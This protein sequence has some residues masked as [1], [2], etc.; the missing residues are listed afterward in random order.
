MTSTRTTL[1]LVGG[2]AV[3]AV[4]QGVTALPGY[5]TAAPGWGATVV[6]S[7]LLLIA[8][9]SVAS[10]AAVRLAGGRPAA[11]RTVVWSAIVVVAG[12]AVAVLVPMLLVP[13]VVVASAVLSAA[14]AGDPCGWP[15]PSSVALPCAPSSSCSCRSHCRCWGGWPPSP[16]D[17]S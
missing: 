6:L 2:L 8:Q 5:A 1:P 12:T 17:S 10:L 11:A 4:L 7:A 9:V 3:G 15:R 14:A 16:A 13:F